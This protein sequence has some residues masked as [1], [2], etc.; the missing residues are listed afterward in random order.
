[1]HISF[2]QT[3]FICSWKWAGVPLEQKCVLSPKTSGNMQTKATSS[4]QSR[5]FGQ[6]C[7]LLIADQSFWVSQFFWFCFCSHTKQKC[8]VF[9]SSWSLKCDSK[10]NNQSPILIIWAI[11]PL[12]MFPHFSFPKW[13]FHPP[14]DGCLQ[15][16]VAVA[17]MTFFLWS[18]F[19]IWNRCQWLFLTKFQLC[20]SNVIFILHSCPHSVSDCYS[21]LAAVL[22]LPPHYLLV[23]QLC[24]VH[25]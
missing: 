10:N 5:T 6:M 1:M 11:P 16:S 2:W 8:P 23:F 21:L 19:C 24:W 3:C 14:S 13:A 22:S 4:V 12:Q 15:L 7:G 17:N 9:I 20:S 18:R 25:R